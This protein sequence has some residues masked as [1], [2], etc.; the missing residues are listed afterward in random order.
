VPGVACS[1]F[2]VGSPFVGD[3]FIN[4]MSERRDQA[5]IALGYGHAGD[6]PFHCW[7]LFA[8]HILDV[9]APNPPISPMVLVPLPITRFTVGY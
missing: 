4:F 3:T 1:R 6:H 7:Q 5:G 2:T 8:L 9:S